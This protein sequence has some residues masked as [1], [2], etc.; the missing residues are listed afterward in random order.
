[1]Q[2]RAQWPVEQEK[3]VVKVPELDILCL[4]FHIFLFEKQK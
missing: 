4:F 2:S 1:M 3:K